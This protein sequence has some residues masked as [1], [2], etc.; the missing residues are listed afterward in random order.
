MKKFT[1]FI[2]NMFRKTRSVAEKHTKFNDVWSADR[3]V[4]SLVECCICDDTNNRYFEVPNQEEIQKDYQIKSSTYYIYQRLRAALRAYRP[5]IVWGNI[6]EDEYLEHLIDPNFSEDKKAKVISLLGDLSS[7]QTFLL[8]QED[9]FNY[10]NRKDMIYTLFDYICAIDDFQKLWDRHLEYS[11][12]SNV[13]L[14]FIIHERGYPMLK[15][16]W[17]AIELL[18]LLLGDCYD[19]VVTTA[20]LV[21]K[22]GYPSISDEELCNMAY[23]EKYN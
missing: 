10:F 8:S 4:R 2:L 22:Y 14:D 5:D 21:D 3:V 1:A 15:H 19:R 18:G 13:I 23:D 11:K 9:I 16:Q 17:K 12:G 6:A 20:E 7:Q